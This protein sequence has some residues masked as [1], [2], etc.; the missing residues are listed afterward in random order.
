[1]SSQSSPEGILQLGFAFWASRTFL[2]AIE[3]G[4][5]TEIARR[6]PMTLAGIEEE[7]ALHRRSSRDFL[8]A[9]VALG[10]LTR[11]AAGRYDNTPDG[12]AFLDRNKP[13]YIGGILEMCSH[14]L[15]PFWDQLPE[16][17][18]DGLPKNEAARGGAGF[19]QELYA[20]P[21][22]LKLFLQS[23]TGLSMGSA[24]AIARQF[25]WTRYHTV[26]DIGCAQGNVS[27]QVA[28][29]HG[30]ITGGGFDLPVVQP[31]FDHYINSFELGGRLKFYPGDFMTDPL[32]KADVL[33][34]G[35]ILHDWDLDQKH[36]LLRKAYD[37]LPPGGALIVH[38]AIIDDERRKNA[39]G[40]L[41]SLNMLI[42]TPGGFD[43]TGA[44][45]AKWMK[46]AGFRDIHIEHLVGPDSMVVAIK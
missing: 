24:L 3:M 32:P 22:R 15:Y 27:V 26:I 13:S 6:G 11:D 38:E 40:L 7:F 8:D 14:R 19:F 1:M 37:A 29:A 20:D 35:H 39:F 21:E 2:A 42:E 30:H 45:C 36:M 12:A 10:M 9:L 34:M 5:F 41:M 23:M 43:F 28:L 4:L 25:P 31:I 44:D 16:A 33:V 18:R 46:S 17:L